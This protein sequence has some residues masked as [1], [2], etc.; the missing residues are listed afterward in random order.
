MNTRSD[1]GSER[2]SPKQAASPLYE[3]MRELPPLTKQ[4]EAAINKWAS[5]ANHQEP[6]YQPA[7]KSAADMIDEITKNSVEARKGCHVS[8]RRQQ[9]RPSTA[10]NNSR[11]QAHVSF[12]SP[13]QIEARIQKTLRKYG[14]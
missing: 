9:A 14:L 8:P 7:Y 5:P 12:A 13:T 3:A 10:G 6:N 1:H 2:K 4:Q 11:Q